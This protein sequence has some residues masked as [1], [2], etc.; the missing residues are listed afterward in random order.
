M[1]NTLQIIFKHDY[2]FCMQI[3][4]FFFIKNAAVEGNIYHPFFRD[5]IVPW[6]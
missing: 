6:T 1:L 4:I 2:I 5:Q 3:I